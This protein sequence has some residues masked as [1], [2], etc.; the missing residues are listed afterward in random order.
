[1]AVELRENKEHKKGT[2][3]FLFSYQENDNDE[4]KLT[5][6]TEYSYG[7]PQSNTQTIEMKQNTYIAESLRI[8]PKLHKGSHDA[9]LVVI[10]SHKSRFG[11]EVKFMVCFYLKKA[12]NDDMPDIQLPLKTLSLDTWMSHEKNPQYYKTR[13]DYHVV[14]CPG[15]LTINGDDLNQ[16]Q[17][18]SKSLYKELMEPE[19]FDVLRSIV[20]LQDN[21]TN[22]VIDTSTATLNR[23]LVQQESTVVEGFQEG[24][25]DH[26]YMECEI[27]EGD[28]S[29]EYEEY[30]LPLKNNSI[31]YWYTS[32]TTV[33]QGLA[34]FLVFGYAIPPIVISGA[35]IDIYNGFTRGT[36]YDFVMIII[37]ILFLVMLILTF[38]TKLQ[39][40]PIVAVIC[41][42][43]YFSNFIGYWSIYRPEPN[44]IV[45]RITPY[46]NNHNE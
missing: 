44:Q 45:S 10:H 42:G 3:E 20:T 12:T 6:F 33:A 43:I 9:E 24:G 34:L 13:N 21:S 17:G 30:A 39:F 37:F 5:Y 35:N 23:K 11:K 22:R 18:N 27:L 4:E 26:S 25:G 29:D 1:M 46:G 19:V 14:I 8:T 16:L 38:S 15:P 2:L 40:A 41:S 7:F 31:R 32:V 36:A 28:D